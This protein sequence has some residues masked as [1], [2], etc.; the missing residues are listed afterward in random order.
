LPK[1]IHIERPIELEFLQAAQIVSLLTTFTFSS[2]NLGVASADR[3]IVVTMR[4]R[5]LAGGTVSSA[6]IGGVAATIHINRDQA[7]GS[8]AIIS[9]IVPTGTT[10]D[11]VINWSQSQ[12]VTIISAY[13]IKGETSSTP[14]FTSTDY[15]SPLDVTPT[16]SGLTAI[17]AA[18]GF[19]SA[20]TTCTY[21]GTLGLVENS[22]Q[23]GEDCSYSSASLLTSGSG[24]VTATPLGIS[25]SPSLE[26]I[27]WK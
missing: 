5:K 9:A 1:F 2:Q 19:F 3:R 22:D 4:G 16:I 6:T 21:G 12:A 18:A 24:N 8:T 14:D 23:S 11:I 7:S 17:I 27:G 25:N 15:T 26:V 13:S 10:G 20:S